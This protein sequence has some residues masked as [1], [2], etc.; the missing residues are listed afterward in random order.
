MDAGSQDSNE[1][2]DESEDGTIPTSDPDDDTS[3]EASVRAVEKSPRG[4]FIRFNKRLGT[5]AFKVVY[6][7]FD[8]DT[9]CE[10]AW[11]VLPFKRLGKHERKQINTEIKIASMLHH[12]RILRYKSSWVNRERGEVVFISDRISG[13][14]LWSYIKRIGG[15]LKLKLIRMWGRQILEGL[16]YLHALEPN[17]VIH[18]DI[19]CSNIFVSSADGQVV[20]G[21]LGLC[22]S[23]MMNPATSLVGTP[24]FMAPEMYDEQYGTEV[25]I[26]AFGMSLLQMASRK[27]PFSEC[28]TTGQVYKYIASGRRPEDVAKIGNEDLRR[29]IEA[30]ICFDPK[31]RPKASELLRD[32]FWDCVEKGNNLVDLIIPNLSIPMSHTNVIS[33]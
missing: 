31:S 8:N 23:L 25:D 26:Y 20:I 27:L 18:R 16:E 14:S 10:V 24:E 12:P 2:L 15:P 28:S 33:Y 13:G 30:C 3:D 22:T 17:P 1:G 9:G 11:N 32:P 19:K 4:R 21:D 5:G 7:A 29:I 6:L